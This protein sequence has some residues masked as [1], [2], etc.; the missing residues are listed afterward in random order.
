MFGLVGLCGKCQAGLE[1]PVDQPLWPFVG[2]QDERKRQ[3]K[4]LKEEEL[5]TVKKERSILN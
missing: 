4:K 5:E 1:I 2:Q 3:A